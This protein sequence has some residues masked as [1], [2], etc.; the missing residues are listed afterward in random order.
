[1]FIAL[2]LNKT[3]LQENE[4]SYKY[5]KLA[6]VYWEINFCYREFTFQASIATKI[7]FSDV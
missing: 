7:D 6:I 4:F 5:T 3:S 2:Q 1:M